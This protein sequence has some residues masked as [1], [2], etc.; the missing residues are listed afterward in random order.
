MS[1]DQPRH[2]MALTTSS[3]AQQQDSSTDEP[4]SSNGS[5]A[6]EQDAP[7][8]I[9]SSRFARVR[10]LSESLCES[11]EIEDFVV[12]SM[13]DVSPTRW[14][15]AHTTWFFETFVLAAHIK[16]YQ[17][18]N[19]AFQ[20]LFNSYYNQV[21]EQFPRAKRGLI[22]RPTVSEVFEYRR[23]VDRT[24]S[25]LLN[26]VSVQDEKCAEILSL[27]ELG[28]HHEQQHQELMLTDIKHVLSCN[29]LSPV[30]RDLDRH[31]D[32]GV[33]SLQWCENEGGIR[34]Q[35]H[36]GSAFAFDNES[37]RHETLLHPFAIGSRLVTCGEY[38]EFIEDGGY[39]R[40]ELWLSLGWQAVQDNQWKA[41]LYWQLESGEWRI[42]TLG[43]RRSV[44]AS[45]PVSHVSY[46]EADA[47]ARWRGA[48]LPLESEWEATIEGMGISGNFV[49]SNEL[50]PVPL[51]ACNEA[52]SLV[53][54]I[55][56]TSS[57]SASLPCQMYGD[58]W[59]WTSSPYVAY[60]EYRPPE[61]AVGEYNG[62]FMC[63]QFVLRGGSCATSRE[64]IRPTYRNFFPP[65][66]RWQF[67][68][69]RLACDG[70]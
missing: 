52:V 3:D 57:R 45:E 8:H 50:H 13:P 62:K 28:L 29:P 32:K 36:D 47:Y 14:H 41:P 56:A 21:G 61:G 30:F 55:D 31:S 39:S 44:N 68:G 60:P 5:F 26:S 6:S 1:E 46:L 2:A 43:G 9:M 27:V 17:S 58:L 54:G 34:W 19:P 53:E 37:P 16:G 23:Q 40:P 20:Y 33:E 51:G 63:N 35:G 22:T 11:L 12:Q 69:I 18:P 49:E 65:D 15:L 4:P 48:R 38:L 70:S 67:T 25:E 59:E 66:A 42:F 7:S 10:L 64:H 24:L